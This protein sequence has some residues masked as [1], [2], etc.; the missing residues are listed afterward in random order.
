MKKFA[1]LALILVCFCFVLS[2]SAAEPHGVANEGDAWWQVVAKWFNFA[3]LI[4]ILY[5]F[6][7]KS[8]RVQDQYK[9]DAELIQKSI[10][11]ARQAKEEAE[12]RLQ[13]LDQRMQKMGEEI[14]SIKSN[15]EKEAEEEKLRILEAAHK[16]AERIVEFAQREIENEVTIARQQLRAAVA[17]SAVDKSRKI[18]EQEINDQDHKRLVKEY[19]E[20]FRK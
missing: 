18:I 12:K 13:E 10:E 9:S 14:A 19:I 16:E 8:L 20:G 6:L 15:A 4:G 11:S 5:W 17:D 2:V 3:V 7:G 1:T